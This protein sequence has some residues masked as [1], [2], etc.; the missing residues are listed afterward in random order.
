MRTE[1]MGI[2]SWNSSQYIEIDYANP[3]PILD[4]F[5]DVWVCH[6]LPNEGKKLTVVD[7]VKETLDANLNDCGQSEAEPPVFQ[8]GLV[9]RPVESI[10]KT[11]FSEVCSED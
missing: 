9:R 1:I 11:A 8:T 6:P 5:A 10:A 3:K 4:E 2:F 7:A